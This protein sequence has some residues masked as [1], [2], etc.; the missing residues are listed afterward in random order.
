MKKC[1]LGSIVSGDIA[2]DPS[3]TKKGKFQ[4]YVSSFYVVYNFLM[5]LD[6][7]PTLPDWLTHLKDVTRWKKFAAHLLP[8]D[9]A[10]TEISLIDSKCRGDVGESKIALYSTFSEQGE[11]TWTRVV[12]ALEES[13]HSNIA[14]QI[15]RHFNLY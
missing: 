10:A 15:K 7:R 13:S 14:R 12:K 6:C 2:Q 4:V 5:S 3:S 11:M 9:S 1:F 8:P